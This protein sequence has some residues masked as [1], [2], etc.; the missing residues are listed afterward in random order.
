VI[1][2]TENPNKL[3][4]TRFWKEKS[5]ENVVTLGPTAQATLVKCGTIISTII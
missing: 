3:Q 5:V 4:K 1:S 2:T